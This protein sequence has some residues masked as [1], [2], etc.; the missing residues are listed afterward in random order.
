MC[1][2]ARVMRKELKKRGLEDVK[3]LF[4]EEKPLTSG[5][6]SPNSISYV[7]S[8]GGLVIA[9]EVIRDLLN[10]GKN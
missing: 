7:P 9:G 8:T 4:S 5:R 1:P 6:D 2:L 10:R 3:V